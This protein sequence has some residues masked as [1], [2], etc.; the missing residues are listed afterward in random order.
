MN[1][2]AKVSKGSVLGK[3]IRFRV[4]VIIVTLTLVLTALSYTFFSYV[5]N[6]E[7]KDECINGTNLLNAKFNE[8]RMDTY[9]FADILA[10]DEVLGAAM[11]TGDNEKVKS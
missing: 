10:N 8:L 1:L 4:T 5:I 7:L 2:R 11:A 6:N 3:K 9:D